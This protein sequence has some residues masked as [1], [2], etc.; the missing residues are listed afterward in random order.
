[1]LSMT[2]R[3]SK[4]TVVLE[5]DMRSDD[6][7][8]LINAIKQ[9]RGVLDVSGDVMDSGSYLAEARVRNEMSKK[10]WEVLYP[11]T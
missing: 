3:Y 7:E 10:L 4:L 8:S 1:M 6:A 9:M 2:D 11:K 5:T